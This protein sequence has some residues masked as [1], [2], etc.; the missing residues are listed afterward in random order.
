[1]WWRDLYALLLV[2][3][4]ALGLLSG[5]VSGPVRFGL[6]L[7][8]SSTA[9]STPVDRDLADLR[10]GAPGQHAAESGRGHGG[11]HPIAAGLPDDAA[12]EAPAAWSTVRPAAAI[13]AGLRIVARGSDRAPPSW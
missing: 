13:S 6:D 1:V 4:L 5:D 11:T 10:H 9:T 2:V 7:P 8:V 3:G 12:Q